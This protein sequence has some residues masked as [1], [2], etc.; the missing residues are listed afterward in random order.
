MRFAILIPTLLTLGSG[1]ATTTQTYVTRSLGQEEVLLESAHGLPAVMGDFNY[2]QGV[3]KGH[4]AWTYDCRRALVSKQVTETIETKKPN[5]AAGAGLIA[6]GALVGV[7][8]GTLL[9][10]AD[11]Y[12]DVDEC[13][14]DSDGYTTCASPRDKAYG[15][16]VLGVLTSAFSV[17]GGLATFGMRTTSQVTNSEPAP[18]VVSRTVKENVACGSAPVQ[19]IG[20]ALV[21]ANT[22]VA[23]SATN[24]MGEVAFAVPPNVTGNMMVMVDSVP[25]PIVAIHEGDVIGAVHVGTEPTTHALPPTLTL[26]ANA[27]LVP[28]PPIAP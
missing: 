18:P 20:L 27:P 28:E 17:G 13:S 19:N 9:S 24:S 2:A 15:I 21:R 12:S 22:R 3:V 10:E 14:T 8:S 6:L 23:F 7:L 4:V 5:H 11:T 25:P 1:C 26:P 16:G